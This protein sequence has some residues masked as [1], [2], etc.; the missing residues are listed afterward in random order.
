MRQC[1]GH[2]MG[3]EDA[4]AQ[5]RQRSSNPNRARQFPIQYHEMSSVRDRT[6]ERLEPLR[7]SKQK[8]ARLTSRPA[9]FK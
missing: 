4:V 9:S 2:R 8:K 1:W 6:L 3:A 5:L 7:S